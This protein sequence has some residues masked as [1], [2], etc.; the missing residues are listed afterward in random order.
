MVYMGSKQKLVSEFQPILQGAVCNSEKKIYYEPF[1]GGANVICKIHATVRVGAD[2]NRYI[3]ELLRNLDKVAEM[4]DK[5]TREEYDR[6]RLA[7]R[8]EIDEFIP[9]WYVAAVGFLA[10]YNGRFF[11]GGFGASAK[12]KNGTRNYFSERKG[13][14]LAQR[15]A[16]DG[17]L[18]IHS[19]YRILPIPKGAV[20]YCDPPYRNTKQY[21]DAAAVREMDDFDSDKFW[22]WAERL[23]KGGADVYVSEESAPPQWKRVWEKPVTR[24]LDN[25]KRIETVEC[26]FHL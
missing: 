21:L 26:L 3:I 15:P 2:S 8:K 9:A 22:A 6:V 24:T 4:T 12:T 17:V 20:V 7:Y 5:I 1:V 16:L 18:F 25:R 23:H 14:L 11:T 10:S 13:N 19:D